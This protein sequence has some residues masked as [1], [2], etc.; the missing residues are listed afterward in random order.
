VGIDSPRVL[1]VIIYDLPSDLE[2]FLQKGGRAGRLW[3]IFAHVL[4]LFSSKRK[5]AGRKP[6]NPPKDPLVAASALVAQESVA[7]FVSCG[8][9]LWDFLLEFFGEEHVPAQGKPLGSC[10][11]N[12]DLAA[13]KR[14]AVCGLAPGSARSQLHKKLPPAVTDPSAELVPVACAV[15]RVVQGAPFF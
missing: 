2:D 5:L 14:L 8:T 4:L 1:L 15:L 7:R 12:C 11:S 3:G 13:P 10:C 6:L 9:C